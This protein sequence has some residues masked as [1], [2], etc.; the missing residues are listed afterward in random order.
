MLP[1]SRDNKKRGREY[2]KGVGVTKDEMAFTKD[3]SD[4]H[5]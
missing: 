5:E 1:S 3:A 2:H 4:H